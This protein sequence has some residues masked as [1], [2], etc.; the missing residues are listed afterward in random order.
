MILKK[1]LPF[2]FLISTAIHAQKYSPDDA[3]SKVHFTIK[4]FGIKTGG[5][6]SGLKGDIYFFTS[7]LAAFRI[8]V[9]V[10]A[11]TVD[12]DNGSRD[13]HLKGSEYFDAE[14]FP[15][16][17]ITSTKIDKTNKTESGFY[18]FNGNLTMHGI[19]K[20]IAFPFHVE[21]VN[22]TYLFTGDFE[23]DRLDFGV[24]DKSAVL[25][26]TVNVSLSVLA[27]KS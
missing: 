1:L 14:K 5:D 20:P 24:G 7:D 17:T 22:D 15:L 16:I 10:D 12:T 18:Y 25:S 21:K 26:S 13:K 3:G 6:L 9:T 11:A 27:K 2:I 23:I 4:N 19:T 8:T